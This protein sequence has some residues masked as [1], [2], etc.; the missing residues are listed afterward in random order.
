MRN[1]FTIPIAC[2]VFLIQSL[3]EQPALAQANNKSKP[4]IA[5]TFDDGATNDIGKYKLEEWNQL[6]L[7]NLKKHHLRVILFSAGYNKENEKG[8]YLLSSWNDAGHLIGNHT[9]SHPNF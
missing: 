3:F 5:F 2:S 7:D 1:P 8:K 6:L 4:K 9:Y